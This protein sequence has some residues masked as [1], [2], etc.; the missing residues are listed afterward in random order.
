MRRNLSVYRYPSDYTNYN[1]KNKVQLE[2]SNIHSSTRNSQIKE[3]DDFIAKSTNLVKSEIYN[4]D[5]Y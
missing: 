2:N 3:K 1:T 4:E 5:Y